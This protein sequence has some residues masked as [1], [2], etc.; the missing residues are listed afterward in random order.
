ML[1]TVLDSAQVAADGGHVVDGGLDGSDG[2]LG[3][4][5]GADIHAINAQSGDCRR[6]G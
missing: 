3:P 6:E 2:L 1:Q 5:L 4:L